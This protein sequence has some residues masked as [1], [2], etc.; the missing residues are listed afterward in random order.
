ML[1]R[2]KRRAHGSDNTHIMGGGR[3]LFSFAMKLSSSWADETY[4]YMIAGG[5]ALPDAAT[6]TRA[7]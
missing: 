4:G 3:C 2:L 5:D 7:N 6:E 1:L